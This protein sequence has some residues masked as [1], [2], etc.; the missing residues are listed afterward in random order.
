MKESLKENDNPEFI[1]LNDTNLQFAPFSL[2]WQLPKFMQKPGV[3]NSENE[4]KN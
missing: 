2:C 4:T 1:I 3:H